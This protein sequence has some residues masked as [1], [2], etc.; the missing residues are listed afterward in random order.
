M[1]CP[2]RDIHF[3]LQFIHQVTGEFHSYRASNA[4]I[5]LMWDRINCKT[6]SQMTGDMRLHDVHVTSS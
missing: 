5:S 4:D 1:V 2:H 3:T 6:N